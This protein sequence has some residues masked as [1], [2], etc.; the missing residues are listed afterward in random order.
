M[1]GKSSVFPVISGWY[2]CASLVRMVVAIVEIRF[3][4]ANTFPNRSLVHSDSGFIH[5]AKRIPV[6]D[7]TFARRSR[8][9]IRYPTNPIAPWGVYCRN[10]IVMNFM[11]HLLFTLLLLPFLGCEGTDEQLPAYLYLT[12]FDLVTETAEGSDSERVTNG[13]LYVGA[14][15]LGVVNLDVPIPVLEEGE[16]DLRFDPV[17]R[18]NGNSFTLATYPFYERYETTINLTPLQT[19]T[20]RPVV[21]YRDGVTFKFVE[22]FNDPNHLFIDDRD[23]DLNTFVE[24]TDDNAFEGLSGHIVLT[25]DHPTVRVATRADIPFTI[26]RLNRGVFLEINFKTDVQLLFGLIGGDGLGN[27]LEAFEF[28]L[29]EKEEWSKI[30]LDLGPNVDLS[31]FQTYRIIMLSSIDGTDTERAD[32]YLD[33]IKLLVRE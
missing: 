2:S 28:I 31:A 27:E 24:V 17:V 25:Q 32:I 8:S 22:D 33:N 3:E 13:H 16:V 7:S 14:D 23:G 6:S 26:P 30:Y 15:Y 4:S 11:K 9:N 10:F 29:N 18:A 20:I 12:D 21:G 5:G 1:Y 19:D